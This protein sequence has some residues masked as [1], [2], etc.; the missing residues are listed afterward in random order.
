MISECR[1]QWEWICHWL[2]REVSAMVS[3]VIEFYK[4]GFIMQR[5]KTGILRE[6]MSHPKAQRPFY[7]M[8]FAE[9]TYIWKL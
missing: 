9:E 6:G 2:L 7:D 3:E 4:I 1:V 5:K 8:Y